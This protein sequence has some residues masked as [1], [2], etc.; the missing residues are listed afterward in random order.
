MIVCKETLGDKCIPFYQILFL[1]SKSG[2]PLF[3][4]VVLNCRK[5]YKLVWNNSESYCKR[6]KG[7]KKTEKNKR[8]EKK[9]EK[10]FWTGVVQ[11]GPTV[12][13]TLD[14]TEMVFF[15]PWRPGPT[16]RHPLL[17]VTAFPLWNRPRSWSRP[18]PRY[19][20]P[21][22]PPSRSPSLPPRLLAFSPQSPTLETP[23]GHSNCTPEHHSAAA[24]FAGFPSTPGTRATISW[25]FILPS[26]VRVFTDW[27]RS[28]FP[29]RK[30]PSER[31]RQ[32]RPA[33]T[34]AV[35]HISDDLT[36]MFGEPL[37]N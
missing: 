30:K 35:V 25:S 3:Y 24:I 5:L 14:N 8:K 6:Y 19:S 1:E 31:R 36:V 26:L 9:K 4:I 13:P 37:V 2:F 10:E 15:F 33:A 17:P 32:P 34:A 16:C 12:W 22:L 21:Q 29:C 11:S 23:P 18:P 28:P 20:D 27:P 7:N